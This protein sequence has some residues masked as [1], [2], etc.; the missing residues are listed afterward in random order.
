[1]KKIINVVAVVAVAVAGL[2]STGCSSPTYASRQ[3]Q[4]NSAVIGGLLGGAAGGVI[5]NN[6][7]DNNNVPLGIAIG[8]ALGGFA[9]STYGS[10]QDNTRHQIEALQ[11]QAAFSTV[12]VVNGN[13]SVTPVPLA[14]IGN[15][16]Y[17][18]PKGEIYNGLP[19]ADTL[20][21]A[22]YGF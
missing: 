20:K 2:M 11:M 4:I 12:T 8:T 9:G 19:N 21:R 14:S 6:I 13:G 1:M 5:G 17:R 3:S 22:G 16:Q 18:G 10:G 7:G 15:G